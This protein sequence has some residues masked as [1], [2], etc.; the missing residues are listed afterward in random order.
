MDKWKN[1]PVYQKIALCLSFASSVAIP[2]LMVSGILY[3]SS[4]SNTKNVIN[5]VYQNNGNIVNK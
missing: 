4:S 2:I 5:N 3:S 1:L